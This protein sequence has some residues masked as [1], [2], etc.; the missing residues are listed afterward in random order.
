MKVHLIYTKHKDASLDA[1]RLIKIN[2]RLNE[3]ALLN[4]QKPSYR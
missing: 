2:T 1:L 3:I 4:K